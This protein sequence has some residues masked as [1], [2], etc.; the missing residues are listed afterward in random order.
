[1]L[2]WE[3]FKRVALKSYMFLWPQK[4]SKIFK[5]IIVFKIKMF[6]TYNKTL[7][8]ILVKKL[9]GIIYHKYSFI[10]FISRKFI[11]THIKADI[12]K[13][14]IIIAHIDTLYS[15]YLD[16]F[17]NIK[18]IPMRKPIKVKTRDF[19]FNLKKNTFLKHHNL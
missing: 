8:Y 17:K 11:K 16:I 15:M 13:Y 9:K 10:F 12:R 19:K 14:T 3:I 5:K 2:T 18:D 7:Y 6:A 4:F 1:M